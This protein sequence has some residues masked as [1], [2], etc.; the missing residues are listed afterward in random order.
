MTGTRS[1]KSEARPEKA[2]VEDEDSGSGRGG[3][4]DSLRPP[5]STRLDG[6]EELADDSDV[7]AG[8]TTN[9]AR[10]AFSRVAAFILSVCLDAAAID[11]LVAQLRPGSGASARRTAFDARGG[12]EGVAAEDAAAHRSAPLADDDTVPA[13]ALE[14]ALWATGAKEAAMQLE[15]LRVQTTNAAVAE[16]RARRQARVGPAPADAE[17]VRGSAGGSSAAAAEAEAE[18]MKSAEKADRASVE[19]TLG[20][21][22]RRV[23]TLADLHARHARVYEAVVVAK[24]DRSRVGRLT[25]AFGSP[26]EPRDVSTFQ[27]AHV[28]KPQTE[29]LNEGDSLHGGMLMAML[30]R[31]GGRAGNSTHGRGDSGSGSGS[32]RRKYVADFPEGKRRGGEE[33]DGSGTAEDSVRGVSSRDIELAPVA[34][35]MAGLQPLAGAGEPSASIE[36]SPSWWQEETVEAVA[37]EMKSAERTPGDDA[38]T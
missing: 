21:E 34:P 16:L 2:P 19:S 22:F 12:A 20:V 32:V 37:E 7:V 29:R 17:G 36:R 26:R 15:L 6:E 8:A 13:L 18:E 35:P 30:A 25:R 33:S 14:R 24:S 27:P 11:A 4:T 31:Q 1:P 5:V 38:K 9:V 10:A 28:A 23:T 3:F